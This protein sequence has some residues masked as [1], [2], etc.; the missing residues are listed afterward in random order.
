[1][2]DPIHR[3]LRYIIAGFLYAV[4]ESADGHSKNGTALKSVLSSSTTYSEAPA[5]QQVA[6]ESKL[7]PGAFVG[8]KQGFSFGF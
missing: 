6:V 2:G 8:E 4:E 5:V 7:P 3:G 1:M